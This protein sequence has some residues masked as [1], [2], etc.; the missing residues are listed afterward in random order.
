MISALFLPFLCRSC[1]FARPWGCFRSSCHDCRIDSQ[2]VVRAFNAVQAEAPSIHPFHPQRCYHV[3]KQC[4]SRT[5]KG[6]GT[7]WIVLVGAWGTRLPTSMLEL[8]LQA[9]TKALATLQLHPAANTNPKY[10]FGPGSPA[11]LVSVV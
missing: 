1:S 11:D 9:L 3:G 10:S 4:R 7:R 2:I 6:H 8:L 5:R